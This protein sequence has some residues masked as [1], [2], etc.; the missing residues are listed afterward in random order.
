MAK[1]NAM[2]NVNW[3]VVKMLEKRALDIDPTKHFNPWK[4]CEELEEKM[5]QFR[6]TRHCKYMLNFHIVWCPRGRVKI[7]FHEVRVLLRIVIEAICKENNWIAL[8]IEPMPDHIHLFV[9][10]KDSREIV[11]GSSRV[12]HLL[13]YKDAFQYYA[14]HL[15]MGIYGVAAIS[16]R[17]LETCLARHCS[18]ISQSNGKSLETHDM[19]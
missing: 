19:S 5:Q 16:Y 3:K 1:W 12:N 2:R 9:S 18:S 7:L 15:Q 6:S 10:T 17:P 13:F 8:A 14:K 11:L 4:Y